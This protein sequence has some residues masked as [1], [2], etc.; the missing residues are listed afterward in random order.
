MR[1]R[2]VAFCKSCQAYFLVLNLEFCL[3]LV[4][5]YWIG[6]LNISRMFPGQSTYAVVFVGLLL[7]LLQ[8]HQGHA[9]GIV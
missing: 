3:D 2:G 4:F 7:Y 6:I 1:K 5:Y 9:M 8:I